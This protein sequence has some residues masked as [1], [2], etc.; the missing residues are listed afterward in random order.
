ML[1][2]LFLYKKKT[3]QDTNVRQNN[4]EAESSWIPLRRGG[5]GGGGGLKALSHVNKKNGPNFSPFI[6]L[7]LACNSQQ[8]ADSKPTPLDPW[9]RSGKKKSSK[10]AGKPDSIDRHWG[11]GCRHG[12][13]TILST[14]HLEINQVV[15]PADRWFVAYGNLN[16]L[17]NYL[18]KKEDQQNDHLVLSGRSYINLDSLT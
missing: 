15:T 8:T 18:L 7:D 10:H 13:Q 17:S 14:T 2:R 9:K 5:G 12:M 4:G 11:Y 6:G 3:L 16:I 1:Y